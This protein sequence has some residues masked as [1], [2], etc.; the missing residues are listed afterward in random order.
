[1]P[2]I[3]WVRIKEVLDAAN[4]SKRKKAEEEAQAAM[5]READIHCLVEETLLRVPA[6]LEKALQT[7]SETVTVF[8]ISTTLIPG[9]GVEEATRRLCHALYGVGLT[10]RASVEGDGV[11]SYWCVTVPVVEFVNNPHLVRV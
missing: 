10:G 8:E 3:D 1:M 4:E 9:F 5:K 6:K 7:N 11:A 2:T